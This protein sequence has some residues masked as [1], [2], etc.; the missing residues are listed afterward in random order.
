MGMR[1]MKEVEKSPGVGMRERSG[2]RR[3]AGKW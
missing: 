3:Q 2:E 1:N